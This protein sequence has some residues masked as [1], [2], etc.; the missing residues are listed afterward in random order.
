MPPVIT[1]ISSSF[2]P[3]S[4]TDWLKEYWI[5]MYFTPVRAA[6]LTPR[7]PFDVFPAQRHPHRLLDF[8]VTEI[9]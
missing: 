1:T 4:I 8:A 6:A 7:K 9:G 5:Q 3:S 2:T